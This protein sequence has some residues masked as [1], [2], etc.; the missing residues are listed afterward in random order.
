MAPGD[1]NDPFSIPEISELTKVGINRDDKFQQKGDALY[2]HKDTN[3]IF[4]LKDDNTDN[5]PILLKDSWQGETFPAHLF[6]S[7]GDDE[8]KVY[9]IEEV[10]EGD[11]SYYL[12]AIKEKYTDWMSQEKVTQW[13]TVQVNL[14]GIIEWDTSR[15]SESIGKKEELFNEDL[16]RDNIIG[17]NID[18][19][20]L[21]DV[22]ADTKGDTIKLD[23]NNHVYIL[24][25]NDLSLI[26][27]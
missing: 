9:A 4:I 6:D 25:D 20:G 12:L 3:R 17:I 18:A 22:E 24:S 16:D 13:E 8:R 11:D 2:I 27:I 19:L 21:K 23:K 14:D 10:N 7:Y 1:N 26:H 15:R 5:T